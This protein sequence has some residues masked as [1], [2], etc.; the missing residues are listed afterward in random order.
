[1]NSIMMCVVKHVESGQKCIYQRSGFT[2]NSQKSGF[3]TNNT[4]DEV[5][6]YFQ[7]LLHGCYCM[8]VY[9]QNFLWRI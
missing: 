1:M 3:T 9:N 7:N 2:V 8:G 5:I 6:L 4:C